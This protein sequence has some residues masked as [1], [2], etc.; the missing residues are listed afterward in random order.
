VITTKRGRQG[1]TQFNFNTQI[2]IAERVTD[3]FEVLNAAEYKELVYEQWVN[4]GV[5]P[6]VAYAD[7]QEMGDIETNWPSEVFRSALEQRY[8]LSANGGT[9]KTSFYISG[10]YNDQE[11]I[12]IGS[13]FQRYSARLN[14]DHNATDRIKV[15]F[16]STASYTKASGGAGEGYFADPVTSSFFVPPIYPVK[17]EDGSYFFD[18]PENLNY[19]PVASALMDLNRNDQKR[20]LGNAYAEIEL[21]KGL[22]YKFV[23]GIDYFDLGEWLFWNPN[24]PSGQGYNGYSEYAGFERSNWIVTN[25]LRYNKIIDVHTIDVM[26]GQEAQKTHEF[27]TFTATSQFPTDRV[28]T[29]I[30]GAEPLTASSTEEGASLASFFANANYNFD[31]RYYLSVSGRRDGSS[32]FGANN[33][34][35]NF[36]SVG[37]SWRITQE[38]FMAGLTMVDDLR[39]RASY[40]TSGNQDLLSDGDP[41]YYP[42][43][44]LYNYGQDYN[45]S[46]GSGLAQLENPDLRWEKSINMNVGLDFV[47]VSGRIAGTVEYYIRNTEDLL[48]EVPISSTTGVTTIWKNIGAIQNKGWEFTLTTRNVDSEFK[49]ITSLNMSFNKNEVMALNEDEPIENTITRQRIEVGHPMRTFYMVRWAGVNPAD[50]T[51][52]WYDEDGNP[53]M[54][55]A[56]A[57]KVL[58]DY[59][60]DPDFFGSFTNTFSY[61]GINL[62]VQFYGVYGN[63]IFNNSDRYLSSDGGGT[64]N[65]DRRQLDRWQ[66][67]GDITAV[68]RRVDG[69]SYSNKNSTRHLEDGSYLRLKNVT[70][71]YNLP[72]N[73]IQKI[74]IDGL[75]I[76]LTGENAYTWTNFTGWDPEGNLDGTSW[77]AY[78]NART[79]SVGLDLTF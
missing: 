69:A 68:P 58:L 22:K 51:A 24:T 77:F 60:A 46:P 40:G 67:P 43:L 3:N 35:A 28:T 30:N 74:K 48:L 13:D 1:G 20:Y 23:G 66:E 62:D 16:N 53:V 73:L 18:I 50:G 76:Y 10:N 63:A 8:S 15:G 14:V 19:N 33:R 7:I 44:G 78:P 49:W 4:A 79:Y 25:T 12:V 17:N 27:S 41:D 36:G 59:K 32:R 47:V 52:M 9:E 71:S 39:L 61:K 75:R 38:S 2:G 65:V 21:L 6:A 5:D 72:R 57:D 55:Y 64:A 29:M 45:G 34:W 54:S 26:L 31:N 70:L 11:G 37:A 56:D 42:A